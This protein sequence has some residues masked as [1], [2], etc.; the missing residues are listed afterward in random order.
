MTYR[1]KLAHS[2]IW[3]DKNCFLLVTVTSHLFKKYLDLYLDDSQIESQILSFSV[4]SLILFL[5]L[6]ILYW[7]TVD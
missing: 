3:F 6:F 1:I 2:C 7:G 5:K 4:I